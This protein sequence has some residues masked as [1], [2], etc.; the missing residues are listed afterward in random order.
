MAT[1]YFTAT[2]LDGFIADDQES[3]SWLFTTPGGDGQA[4][5]EDPGGA[6]PGSLGYDA[7]YAGVG[8]VVMGG[9]TFRWLARHEGDKH[10]QFT[11]P[12]AVPSW[13]A[14]RDEAL[15]LPPGVVRH[16]GE[17]AP[18][19]AAM[20]AAADGK[21]VWIVGGGD[22][23]GKFADAGLLDRVWIH[24]AAVTVG[25]GAP[26][27]PRRLRLRRVAGEFDGQFTAAVFDVLGPE[28][29]DDTAS[30]SARLEA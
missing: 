6:T 2:T 23:A 24:Q 18:L 15:A 3:L 20:T 22:L 25:A 4:A 5:G 11:W 29:L 16:E 27:L 1:I 17:V 8:A 13:V 21:D 26:L 9:N 7:F 10:G 19:H 28:P 14:T 12:Y 30:A